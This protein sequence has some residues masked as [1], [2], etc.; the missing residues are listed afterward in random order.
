MRQP[1]MSHSIIS[2][3]RGSLIERGQMI[4]LYII[5]SALRDIVIVDYVFTIALL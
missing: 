1:T 2:L 5:G 3:F 4:V